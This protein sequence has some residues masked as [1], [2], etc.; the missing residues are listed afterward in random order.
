[1]HRGEI[2]WANLP[3]PAGSEP[4]Y[5]R[6]ILVIQNDTFTQ[7]RISTVIV[8]M[9][10]SNIQ[11]AEAPGN[12]L[13]PRGVSGLSRESVANVSQIFTL[14]KTFL[15]ER[16]GSLPDYL[17]EEIDEGLRTVLYL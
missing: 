11:L 1:M 2:W 14:D 5:R 12:V 8:V 17:Q 10:T 15:V 3:D 9:I 4:G 7:S 13:L 6:P 16:I